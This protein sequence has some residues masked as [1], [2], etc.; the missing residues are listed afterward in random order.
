MFNYPKQLERHDQAEET[1]RHLSTSCVFANS[2]FFQKLWLQTLIPQ[3]DSSSSSC[4]WCK[5]MKAVDKQF[6]K[7]LNTLIIPI[8]W[9][10]W[11]HNNVCISN[12]VTLVHEVVRTVIVEGITWCASGAKDLRNCHG[13][14]LG[15][16]PVS[17]VLM[18]SNLCLWRVN[19][20]LLSLCVF[21]C[22]LFLL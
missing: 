20:Y 3:S 10:L 19:C 14:S 16:P 11:K 18:S 4:W 15:P 7:G 13:F 21:W 17:F 2:I 9:E 5:M 22:P 1:I 12:N 6:R 8:P